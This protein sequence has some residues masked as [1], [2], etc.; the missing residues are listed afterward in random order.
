MFFHVKENLWGDS[1]CCCW[2][3]SVGFTFFG[4]S[5]VS[6]LLSRA[7]R[8]AILCSAANA[9]FLWNNKGKRLEDRKV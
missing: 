9:R 7:V 1:F 5:G 6:E 2:L 4:S 8:S 3:Q